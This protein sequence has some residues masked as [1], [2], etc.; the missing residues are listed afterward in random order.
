MKIYGWNNS[1][2]W[3]VYN[4]I[5]LAFFKMFIQ[6]VFT[7]LDFSKSFAS[8]IFCSKSLL[9]LSDTPL[10]FLLQI[11]AFYQRE[12]IYIHVPVCHKSIFINLLHFMTEINKKCQI[13]F[14]FKFASQFFAKGK[15][16]NILEIL[17]TFSMVF[18]LIT[19]TFWFCSF[20]FLNSSCFLKSSALRSIIWK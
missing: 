11:V 17:L 14:W 5:K 16:F 18:P 20:C 9:F 19:L 6:K 7:Y 15:F 4:L 10:F 3:T 1:D 13:C 2:T 8:S 12:E